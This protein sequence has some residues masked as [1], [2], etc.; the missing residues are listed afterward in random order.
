MSVRHNSEAQADG[1]LRERNAPQRIPS[2]AGAK[3]TVQ[4]LNDNEQ[5]AAKDEKDK[6]TFGRTPN[7]TGRWCIWLGQSSPL[8]RILPMPDCSAHHMINYLNKPLDGK[9]RLTRDAV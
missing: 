1:G 7:G 3:A 5:H 6:K 8:E 2:A 9:D 4:N